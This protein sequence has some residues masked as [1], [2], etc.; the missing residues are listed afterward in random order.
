MDISHDTEF[1]LQ[2]AY[3]HNVMIRTD[4]PSSKPKMAKLF[5]FTIIKIDQNCLK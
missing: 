5:L 4:Y 1:K 3:V 2:Y